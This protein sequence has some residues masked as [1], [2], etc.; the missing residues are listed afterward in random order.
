MIDL[1]KISQ[2]LES[3]EYIVNSVHI[4]PS[5]PDWYLYRIPAPRG[6]YESVRYA[7]LNFARS[8][9]E[10]TGKPCKMITVRVASIE[11]VTESWPHLRS[12]GPAD[13]A[14]RMNM[15]E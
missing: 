6:E 7:A 14:K 15:L 8:E 4:G 13:D 3:V 5:S 12:A 2:M 1:I 10:R 9:V 11:T